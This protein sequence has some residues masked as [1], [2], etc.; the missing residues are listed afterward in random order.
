M[1]RNKYWKHAEKVL[2]LSHGNLT[3]KS[4]WNFKNCEKWK[5]VFVTCK[6]FVDYC[7]VPGCKFVFYDKNREKTNISLFTVPKRSK[8]EMAQYVEACS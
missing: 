1:H 3:R 7:C 8:K 6:C 4:L 2:N 5:K